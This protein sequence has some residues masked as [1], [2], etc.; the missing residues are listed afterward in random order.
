MAKNEDI[1]QVLL[2][3]SSIDEL[4]KKKIDSQIA[5]EMKLARNKPAASKTMDIKEVSP[6]D[7]FTKTTTFLVFNRQNKQESYINGIQAESL[8]GMQPQLREKL[9][10][11][12]SD[13][14]LTENYYVKF[15]SAKLNA[16][17]ND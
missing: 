1:E 17:N 2:S 13:S 12:E 6:Q 15:H 11:K 7:I 5:D 8:T 10:K 9:L 4:I 14:F 16:P 3:G